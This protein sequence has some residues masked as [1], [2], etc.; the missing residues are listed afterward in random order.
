MLIIVKINP[1]ANESNARTVARRDGRVDSPPPNDRTASNGHHRCRQ[2][3]L[4][5]RR[6]IDGPSKAHRWLPFGNFRPGRP[7]HRA[8][9]RLF[10]TRR[11]A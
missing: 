5:K 6:R 11:S 7:L 2:M 1:L 3:A 4:D 8:P 10:T 9:I